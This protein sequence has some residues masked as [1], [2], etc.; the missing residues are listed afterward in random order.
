[1]VKLAQQRWAL[2][3]GENGDDRLLAWI[4]FTDY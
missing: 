4:A 2:A 1:M 3:L